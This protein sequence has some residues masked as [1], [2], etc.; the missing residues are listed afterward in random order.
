[1]N[2]IPSRIPLTVSEADFQRTV[3][4][5]AAWYGWK[6]TH[7]RPAM[8][9]SGRWVTPMIGDVGVPD[10]LLARNGQVV[11]AEL[12]KHGS[13]PTPGQ[14]AWLAALGAHGRLWTPEQWPDVVRTLRDG[15]DQRETA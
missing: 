8:M 9:Q 13:K 4:D 14:R 12:K 15:P 5:A 3:M 7:F 11:L 2:G 6:C 1:M 10:L